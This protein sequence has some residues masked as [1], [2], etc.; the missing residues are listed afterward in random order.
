[1]GVAWLD[2]DQDGREE[3]FIACDKEPNLLLRNRPDGTVEEGGM[4]GGVALV[5]MGT[6]LSGM[7]VAV[8][9]YDNDGREDLHV[10]NFSGQPN[11]LYRS[12]GGGLF[13]NTTV[14]SGISEPSVPLLGW[15]CEF[16]DYDRDGFRDLVVGN[17]HIQDDIARRVE[18]VTYAE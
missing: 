18:G 1:M 6:P 15:G 3:L 13:E 10:T 9:D 11:S 7:G 4:K 14:A 16:L 2:F 8:G 17:G 5:E 12:Q